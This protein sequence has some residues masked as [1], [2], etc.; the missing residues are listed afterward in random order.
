MSQDIYSRKNTGA[1]PTQAGLAVLSQWPISESQ[2][3]QWLVDAEYL[4]RISHINLGLKWE[5]MSLS[6]KTNVVCRKACLGVG[7]SLFILHGL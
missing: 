3:T 4:Y 5:M 6:G 2:L 7:E 1:C